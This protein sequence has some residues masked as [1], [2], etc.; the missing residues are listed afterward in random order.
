MK[1]KGAIFDFDG[2]LFDSMS[3]WETAGERYL[4]SLGI[5]AEPH[6]HE[7]IKDMSMGQSAEYLKE[8]YNLDFSCEEI[9]VGFNKIVEDFYLT[10]ALP[11]KGVVELLEKLKSLGIIMCV[12]TVTERRLIE[13]ALERCGMRHF[14]KKVL[15][16]GD[17]GHGKDKPFIYR[18]A[19]GCIGSEHDTTVV[20]ED[21]LYAMRTAKD[22][23]FT[24]VGVYD[25]SEM[26]QS[27]LKKFCDFFIEDYFRI[28]DFLSFIS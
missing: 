21:A 16:C 5:K 12:A 18:K 10:I 6:L 25:K 17:V 7:K 23:G 2:T 1:I 19:M 13:A 8:K 22:D 3:I 20:F 27:E 24:T 14:F 11:K 26:A 9:V 15:T 28:D 4:E